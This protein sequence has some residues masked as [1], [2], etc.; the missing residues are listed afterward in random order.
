M[1]CVGLFSA[2]LVNYL[3]INSC[4]VVSI[5]ILD[6]L[7]DHISTGILLQPNFSYFSYIYVVMVNFFSIFS[8]LQEKAKL[9]Q[10]VL[11]AAS[12]IE[13][14]QLQDEIKKVNSRVVS[15]REERRKI[16]IKS[17]KKLETEKRKEGVIS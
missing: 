13:K 2:R 15:N 17:R 14:A 6:D 3:I 5:T 12:D 8:L 11:E 1:Y 7:E 4:T 9:E 10:Q 16:I